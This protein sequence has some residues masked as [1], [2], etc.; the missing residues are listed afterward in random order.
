[1]A[2]GWIIP[3][4]CTPMPCPECRRPPR[5][6]RGGDVPQIERR[7]SNVDVELRDGVLHYEVEET[8][9]NRGGGVGEA[10]YLFPL[11]KNAAFEGL[12]LEIN[13][14]LVAGET[15]SADEARRIYEDIVR[16]SRDPALVE[17]MG[18]GLL[19]TRI[20]PINAGETRRVVVRFHA[21]AEREGDAVRVD[22][23]RGTRPGAAADINGD[24]NDPEGRLRFQ[25]TYP[26]EGFGRP[27]S[28]THD[29]QVSDERGT[30]HVELSGGAREMTLLLPMRRGARAAIGVLSHAPGREEGFALFTLSPPSIAPRETPRDVT[31]V[32]DVSGSMSGKKIQQA[33][34]AGKQLLATLSPR[35]RF[36]LID[37]ASDVNT[38]RDAFVFATR[39]NIED[40]EEYLDGLRAEGST[41]ISGALEEALSVPTDDRRL[42]VILFVTDGEPTVGERDPE[43]I[44]ERAATA[45]G[46]RRVFTFG[47]GADLNVALLERLALEGRGTAHFVRP[48]ES[49]ERAV[50]VVASRLTSPVA[51]DL[52]IRVE[53]ARLSKMHPAGPYDLFAGQD[54]VVLARYDGSGTILV[55]FE[56]ESANGPVSWTTEA[57]LP[58]RDRENGFVARL[59]ATQRVGYL[60]AERRR[61]GAS[62]E[63]DDEIRELG[64][65]YGIPTELTSYLVLEPG[66]VALRGQNSLNGVV[67]AGRGAAAPSVAQERLRRFDEAKAASAMRD[68]RSL[69]QVE[70]APQAQAAGII[71]RRIGTRTFV[72][73]DSVW[74]DVLFKEGTRLVTV[75]PYSEA[76][77][78]LV[79]ELPDLG[80]AFG[81]G[82]R[83]LV[84]GTKVAVAV[85]PNGSQ[86]LTASEIAAI[87]AA[88]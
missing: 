14:E 36:R 82:E 50:S 58:E 47:V 84:R 57:E 15:M 5:D 48:D 52:R 60:S 37:F 41:N 79:R 81:L 12:K 85:A 54:L 66:Q 3:R 27:Y 59:W 77:F 8:F 16:K 39:A 24:R 1:M 6:C 75:Q 64:E 44:A 31:L 71:S 35:D 51:T 70:A 40:A 38:F 13:G 63:I 26:R 80:P 69:S 76:Y 21:V 78:A 67:A 73:K 53:G 33:R 86:K 62:Q 45:R 43:R 17:W 20:F 29:V 46:R 34:E 28:P 10:D 30:G 49:V 56:G 87:V 22:Y 68:A 2:Q 18:H 23:F 25:L 42:P 11:P 88:W 4:P 65:K 83:V 61:N 32:L 74:T 55:R 9:V 72:L 19:R 7:A